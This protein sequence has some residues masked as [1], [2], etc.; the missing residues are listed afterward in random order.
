V[1]P[2]A[3]APLPAPTVSTASL[4]VVS[5]AEL[6]A[7]LRSPSQVTVVSVWASWCGPC[8]SELPTLDMLADE[9][10]EV[11]VV[12]LNV[13]SNASSAAAEAVVAGLRSPVVR[14]DAPTPYDAAD[15]LARTVPDWS[16]SIP[17]TVVLAAGG[18]VQKSFKGV[19]SRSELE[20]AIRIA[21]ARD[22]RL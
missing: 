7:M 19:A 2:V 20:G 16:G 6:A 4:P 14:L 9:F 18:A 1:H 10:P 22:P 8:R 11:R 5:E 15:V 3:L 12:L 17:H 21:V 13:D